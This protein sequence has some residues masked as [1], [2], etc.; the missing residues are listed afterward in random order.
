MTTRELNAKHADRR[1]RSGRLATSLQPAPISKVQIVSDGD[2]F[3]VLAW[4][5][6]CRY[7]RL[8]FGLLVCGLQR[9]QRFVNVLLYRIVDIR[10][11]PVMSAWSQKP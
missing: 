4:L 6:A 2:P 10:Q 8:R 3:R 5:F 11:R 1:V 9:E 7:Y